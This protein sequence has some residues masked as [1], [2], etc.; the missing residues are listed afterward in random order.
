MEKI[1]PGN[2]DS[3]PCISNVQM[4]Q[5]IGL[6]ENLQESPMF[7]GKIYGFRFQFSLK[8]IQSMSILVY[9]RVPSGHF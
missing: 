4:S 7:N 6:R 3:K 1:A 8:P 2:D 9:W 5:W